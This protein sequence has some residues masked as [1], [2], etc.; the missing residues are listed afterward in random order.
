MV[1]VETVGCISN[2]F[3]KASIAKAPRF[4]FNR[5]GRCRAFKFFFLSDS[6]F[7]FPLETLV[8][9]RRNE[10]VPIIG[11]LDGCRRRRA[12]RLLFLRSGGF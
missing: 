1:G 8:A 10:N 12:K 6:Q 9:I 3:E 2:L 7:P 11:F 4:G 5:V